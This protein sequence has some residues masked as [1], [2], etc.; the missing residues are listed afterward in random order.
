MKQSILLR[1]LLAWACVLATTGCSLLKVSVSSGDPLPDGTL[2]LRTMTRGLYYDLSSGIAAAADSIVAASPRAATQLAAIRW[3]I[4][5]TRAAVEAAMQSDP[6]VA[7]ADT[8]ILCRR[9]NEAFA[10]MPDSLLFGPQSPI[11]RAAAERFERRVGE[12]SSELLTAERHRLMERFVD[13]YV[14]AHPRP[15]DGAAA[16]NTL[17]AWFEFLRANGRE[18][19]YATGSIS[20]V[21]ADVSDRVGGQTRQL[22]N[23]VGWS[24]EMLEIRMRQDSLRSRV[25][26]QL[27]SL[28]R[29]FGRLVAV[30]EH[31]PELSGQVLGEIN[32]Q[33]AQLI[34]TID[35]SVDAAF[36]NLDRQ[37][38]E[39][40]RY[41]SAEREALIEQVR[42]AA[43]EAVQDALA[44]IPGLVGRVLFYVVT[45]LVV[46]LGLPFLAGFWLGGLRARRQGRR[47]ASAAGDA[48]AGPESAPG[49]GGKSPDMGANGT[50]QTK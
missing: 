43:D 50:P 44:G 39:I 34:G 6:E 2:R 21:M 25:E 5:A 16:P 31:L 19:V 27:D 15:D 49:D 9:M 26:G 10:Q 42:V 35:A 45:A 33:A 38:V 4:R 41:V 46:L 13:E 48:S 30:A 36:D 32:L 18:P 1:S 11:A 3:K 40:Q 8:W 12:L 7:L 28:D 24:K 22:A 20:E 47:Q 23:S 17:L 37:R 29:N 14:R